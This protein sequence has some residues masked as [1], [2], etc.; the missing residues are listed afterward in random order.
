MLYPKQGFAA[1]SPRQEYQ[2]CK[3]AA[4]PNVVVLAAE[5]ACGDLD[6]PIEAAFADAAFNAKHMTKASW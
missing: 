1:I 2:V 4:E 6:V 5:G 3:R